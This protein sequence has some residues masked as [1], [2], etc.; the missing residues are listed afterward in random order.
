[1]ADC[2]FHA[3]KL[4]DMIEIRILQIGGIVLSD[5]R[6]SKITVDIYGQQYT[7]VGDESSSHIRLVASMVDDKMREISA[8]NPALDTGKLAVLTAVNTVH[9]QLQLELKR[10]KD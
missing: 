2:L 8:K 6:K 10:E 9:N 7:I 5:E 1:M 4:H 3:E